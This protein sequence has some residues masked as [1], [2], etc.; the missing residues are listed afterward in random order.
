MLFYKNR[1]FSRVRV[2][3]K[4]IGTRVSIKNGPGEILRHM[5]HSPE[6]RQQFEI[7]WANR[8]PMDEIASTLS[9]VPLSTLK[10]WAKRVKT[11]GN[12]VPF[13]SPGRPEKLNQRD[14]RHLVSKSKRNP[15]L[16]IKSVTEHAG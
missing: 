15:S 7:L 3:I 5:I 13:K 4:S 2:K 16:S 9:N 12:L 10:K 11:K 14:V 8:K 1:F 6:V